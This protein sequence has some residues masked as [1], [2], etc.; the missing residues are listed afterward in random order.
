MHMYSPYGYELRGEL[1]EEVLGRRGQRGKVWDN[2]NST[3]NKI[4]LIK[5]REDIMALAWVAQFVE[6]SFHNQ[7]IAGFDS[8]L[9]YIPRLQV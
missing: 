5:K 9:G 2:C 1:L 4:Y 3:I 7:R 6:A 8:W